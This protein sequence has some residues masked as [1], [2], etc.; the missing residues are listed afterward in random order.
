MTALGTTKKLADRGYAVCTS[1]RSGSNLLCQYLSSTG[2]LG[3][4]LE[5]FNGAGRRMLGYPDFPDEPEKQTDWILT[6]G[7]TSNGIYGVKLFPWQLDLIAPSIRWSR[8]LPNL[9]FVFLKRRDLLG[10]AISALRAAQ[11]QQWRAT[12]P[13]QAPATYDGQ[14][15]YERLQS[16]VRDYARWELFFARNGIEPTVILYENLVAHP[17]DAV[18]QVA[19]LF[20]LQ[21]QARVTE[22]A[23]DLQIQRDLMTEEWRARFLAEFRNLDTLD[24]P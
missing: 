22:Q 8:L 16:A 24:S 10:Q 12:M 7:A 4:P 2:L 19:R 9:A 13:A 15:I 18:D 11:T 6:T 1:G 20:G 21:G 5:Y 17:Q 14:Q 3:H 23:I